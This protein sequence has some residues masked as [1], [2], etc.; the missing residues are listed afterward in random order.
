MPTI[1]RIITHP[2]IFHADDVFAIATL[3][4]LYPDSEVIRETP[5]TEQPDADEI[6]VDVGGKYDHQLGL[7]DHHQNSFKLE[8]TI[9][10]SDEHAWPMASFGLIWKHFGNLICQNTRLTN[11]VEENLVCWIDAVDNG[12][13][14]YPYGAPSL[15][16]IIQNFNNF[17]NMDQ[18]QCF[19][20]AIAYAQTTI[21]ACIARG[22]IE[23]TTKAY[24]EERLAQ[25]TGPILEL[26]KECPWSDS[27]MQ[28]NTRRTCPIL[29]VVYPRS[30]NT[31][32]CQAVSRIETPFIPIQPFPAQ[33]AGR[34][35][36][37]LVVKSNI[38]DAIF[39]HKGRHLLITASK[40][41]ALAAARKHTPPSY[42]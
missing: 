1:H 8:H 38:Q 6:F 36:Q 26:D 30:D 40:Q 16:T 28:L 37:D 29:W 19:E 7:Y 39:C 22:H 35:A 32:G 11:W 17:P 10:P 14:T 2:R 25:T 24:L 4:I 41:S 3:R 13:A 9:V 42:M 18:Y 23:S 15:S 33:W 27:L 21:L 34:V 31:W 5:K 12:I 20:S